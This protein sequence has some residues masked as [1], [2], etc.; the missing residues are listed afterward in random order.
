MSTELNRIGLM[1]STEGE[2][3]KHTIVPRCQHADLVHLV[4]DRLLHLV[5]P[6][7]QLLAQIPMRPCTEDI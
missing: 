2:L 6:L 5:H 3:R 7:R 1:N 4:R